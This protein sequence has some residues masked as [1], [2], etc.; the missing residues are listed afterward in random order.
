MQEHAASPETDTQWQLG[1]SNLKALT[2]TL[3]MVDMIIQYD[4]WGDCCDMHDEKRAELV[5]W[6]EQTEM[7]LK[8]DSV[9]IECLIYSEWADD[10]CD[11]HMEMFQPW[12]Q[13]ATKG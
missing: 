4:D 7:L 9:K 12:R 13:R 5:G 1:F 2:V 6:V 11:N 10:Y 8:A 3:E